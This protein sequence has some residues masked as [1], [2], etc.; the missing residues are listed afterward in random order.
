LSIELFPEPKLASDL[1]VLRD[2]LRA[3][4]GQ[5]RKTLGNAMAAWLK[6]SRKLVDGFLRGHEV[7]PQRR[8]ETLTI[9]EFVSLTRA[10]K[11][12]PLLP[13]KFG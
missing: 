4:F 9:D 10:L 3:A 12:S 5:R 2:L 1:P 7:D 11:D 8:G 6:Q 13:A